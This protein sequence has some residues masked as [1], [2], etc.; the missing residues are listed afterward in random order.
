MGPAGDEGHD[1][2][3]RQ[4]TTPWGRRDDDSPRGAPPD[5]LDRLWV[6]PGRA[7]PRIAAPPG[8]DPA[9]AVGRRCSVP[10]AAGALGAIAAVLVLGL[11]GAFDGQRR[12]SI[13]R[14]RS[15][16]ACAAGDAALSEF[17]PSRR[18]GPARRHGQ[19]RARHAPV[20]RRLRPPPGRRPHQCGDASGTRRPPRSRTTTGEHVAG[21]GRRARRR[22][23]PRAARRANDPCARCRVSES[24][25]HARR[26]LWIFGARRRRTVSAVDQQRHRLVGRRARSRTRPDR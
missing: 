25:S 16:N 11:V 13:R 8:S 24:A 5:R 14:P 6:H 22:H 26:H 7:E 19:R 12:R 20:D 3:R 17:A 2:R 18:A 1:A 23:G 10:V 9:L 15:P 21:E 4:T